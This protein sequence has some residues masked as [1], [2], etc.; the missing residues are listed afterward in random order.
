M[1]I[2]T[3]LLRICVFLLIIS[4]LPVAG[5]SAAPEVPGATGERVLE[6]GKRDF[7][8]PVPAR[9]NLSGCFLDG[10]NQRSLDMDGELG[11]SVIASYPGV[12]EE[13]SNECTHNESKEEVCCGDGRGNY[14]L[15][16]HDYLKANGETI[17]LYSRYSH[18]TEASVE[19]GQSVA[20]GEVIGTVGSTGKSV[21]AHL[22][23]EILY[24]GTS[25]GNSVDPYVNELLELPPELYTS[26]GECCRKYVEAVKEFYAQCAHTQYDELGKCTQ[27]GAAFD[28][29]SS[30]SCKEMGT[31]AVLESTQEPTL[32]YPTPYIEETGVTLDAGEQVEVWGAV[33]NVRGETWYEVKL[34]DESV[35][36]VAQA[37]LVFVEYF[38]TQIQGELSSLQ[39]GQNIMQGSHPL[40][41]EIQSLY[42]LVSL[43]GRVDDNWY[44]SW[45]AGEAVGETT[46]LEL[47]YTAL[48]ANLSFRN[49][50][51]GE[52]TLTI[53]ATDVTGEA[54]T[55]ISCTFVVV[56][57]ITEPDPEP[58]PE[59]EPDPEPEQPKITVTFAMSPE[60]STISLEP[61]QALGKLPVPEAAEADMY[62]YGWFT[63]PEGGEAVTPE[64][65][66]AENM[67]LYPRWVSA[68]YTHKVVFDDGEILVP[69]G[70]VISEPPV[71]TKKGYRF[72]GWYTDDGVLFDLNTPIVEPITLYSEWE[73]MQYTVT[74]NPNG[75][76][77]ATD[78][79][80]V[81]YGSPYGTL[82]KPTRKGYVFMG[83][84]LGFKTITD[85]LQVE[86]TE[87]HTLVAVWR[88]ETPIYLWAL[89]VA[90]LSVAAACVIGH[91]VTKWRR[92][93]SRWS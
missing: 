44:A 64:T 4:M 25:A 82:P 6:G 20:A 5:I 30:R 80:I 71:A 84:E 23:Y 63:A 52:H 37:S 1:K 7:Q 90:G 91:F 17:T 81:T 22:G 19:A 39:D 15:I 60:N 54:V 69:H 50:M 10:E 34:A 40:V 59:P 26:M 27:C 66:P 62:F 35:C 38:A 48:N 12:V 57:E 32:A 11:D 31:Y 3:I 76:E 14:V 16:K 88:E 8:W 92:E 46:Q 65:V 51:P 45:T 41:G 21:G 29:Q 33:K 24:G 87:D 36:Y 61:G 28:W 2:K 58:E 83:W 55:V 77:I 13:V 93:R 18:L 79:L 78:T 56:E 86:A 43:E 70:L 75:G 49:M 68:E 42:P 72:L 85:T 47:R 74:L 9:S 89:P 53:I 73:P 67:T